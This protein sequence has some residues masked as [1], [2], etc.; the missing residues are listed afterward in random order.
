MQNILVPTDFSENAFHALRYSTELL[1]DKDC[2]FFLL[3]VYSVKK[4]FKDKPVDNR[5]AALSEKFGKASKT[6]LKTTLQRI[7]KEST[8][9]KHSYKLISQPGDLTPVVHS[10]IDELKIDLLV[11]GNKGETSSIPQFLGSTTTKTLKSVKKCP[12]L[13]VPRDANIAISG[14]IAFATDFKKEFTSEVLDA[15]RSIALLYGANVRILH[16]DE[17]EGLDKFQKANLD[18]LLNHLEPMAYAVDRLP[19]FISKTKIIQVFMKNSG[20]EMLVMVQ[21]EHGKLE[22]IL[23][24]PIIE[25]MTAK[26][27]NPFLII[28]DA[29]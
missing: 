2:N 13:T 24:E 27:E 15:V 23:R 22:K 17:E 1:K 11:L 6:R 9:A 5:D 12:I 16:I 19:N 28:P 20:I 21:N 25:N 18:I 10:L 8:N 3:N 4:G 26:I 14:E 7:E 29:P